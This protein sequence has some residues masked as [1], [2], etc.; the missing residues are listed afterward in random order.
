M[1]ILYFDIETLPADKNKHVMLAEI[2][3]KKIDDGKQVKELDL[4]IAETS[5]DGAFGRIACISYA[6]N[7]GQIQIICGTE[8]EMLQQ[9]WDIA[10]TI[11]LFVGFNIIDFDMRFI[12][13]RSI[14]NEVKPTRDL[15]F[16]RYRNNPM[17]DL[18]KEWAKWD[19]YAKISL[20]SLAKALNIPSS[21][22]GAM[23]GKDVAK[24]Y[25]DGRIKEI[26]EYCK[27]DVEVTRNIYKKMTFT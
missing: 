20:D 4:F 10:K 25:E 6:I 12:Y 23:E 16:A 27:K 9:F 22:G 5:F 8:K 18:M 3:Q 15:T 26:C 24:A 1:N 13:Q 14:I 21:K 7:D 19:Q 2:H 17:Y 11:E